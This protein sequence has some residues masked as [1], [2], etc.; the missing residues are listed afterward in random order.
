MEVVKLALENGHTY[1]VLAQVQQLGFFPCPLKNREARESD[2]KNSRPGDSNLVFFGPRMKKLFSRVSGKILSFPRWLS[3]RFISPDLFQTKKSRGRRRSW[4]EKLPNSKSHAI[5]FAESIW[6]YLACFS[7]RR[8]KTRLFLSLTLPI[9]FRSPIFFPPPAATP[10]HQ[11]RFVSP[12]RNATRWNSRNTWCSKH[13]IDGP[14][15]WRKDDLM[16][17]KRPSDAKGRQ[18]E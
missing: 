3:E 5:N 10:T 8:K 7:R 15:C 2:C 12:F 1:F 4:E 14:N 13:C 18:G 17:S 9:F 6:E 11:G 16:R